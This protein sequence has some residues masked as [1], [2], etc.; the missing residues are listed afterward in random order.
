MQGKQ[1][2]PPEVRDFWFE[3]RLYQEYFDPNVG[4]WVTREIGAAHPD[5]WQVEV[6]S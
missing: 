5:A 6:E 4:R 1:A 3:G 2:P